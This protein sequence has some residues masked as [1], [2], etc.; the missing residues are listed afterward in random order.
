MLAERLRAPRA[1]AD[2]ALGELTDLIEP[3]TNLILLLAM[4]CII[5]SSDS[6]LFSENIW[7]DFLSIGILGTPKLST[8]S[9]FFGV[10]VRV[11]LN[12]LRAIRY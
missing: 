4:P 5:Y 12:A 11:L 2:Q 3:A 9:L 8:Y 6:V 7:L 10:L 1:L